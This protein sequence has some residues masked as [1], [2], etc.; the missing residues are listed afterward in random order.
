MSLIEYRTHIAIAGS[1]AE[2]HELRGLLEFDAH[3]NAS[4]KR[5]V[6]E[7]IARRFDQLNRQPATGQ[8]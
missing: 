4:E 3:L 1:A 2:L 8:R 6:A 5:A 7:A